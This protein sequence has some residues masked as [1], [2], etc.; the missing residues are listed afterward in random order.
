MSGFGVN[1]FASTLWNVA[2]GGTDFYYSDYASGA[3]SAATAAGSH[4]VVASYSGDASY[5]PS[6]SSPFTYTVKTTTVVL[7]LAPGGVCGTGTTCTAY[8]GDTVPVEVYLEGT[9]CQIPTGTVT[10]TLGSQTQTV[11]LSLEGSYAYQILTGIA[12]F[13]NLTPGTY[14]L[15]AT[16]SGDNNY[17]AGST[18]GLSVAVV[19]PS[20]QRSPTTI[21]ESAPTVQYPAGATTEFTVTVT[22][23]SSSNGAP[24]GT[25]YIYANGQGETAVTLSPSGPNSASG[26]SSPQLGDYF[27]LGL[28]Q[29]TAVYTGDSTYQESLSAPIILTA[30]EARTT[31]NFTL[32]AQTPQFTVPKG[33]SAGTSINLASV[34]GFTG[35]VSLSCTTS[36][37]DIGCSVSPT[38][39]NVNGT[40]Q[41]TL[42]VSSTS[43]AAALGAARPMPRGS[44]LWMFTGGGSMLGCF[45][46]AGFSKTKRNLRYL[47]TMIILALVVLWVAC[48][49]GQ[50]TPPAT[51]PPQQPPPPLSTYGVVVTG[52]AA[53]GT[54][55]NARLTVIVR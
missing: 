48:G 11:P 55:H 46:L 5:N 41:V 16:Y 23:G 44:K 38:S 27:N 8:A 6:Q 30:V 1:G 50:S 49:G 9:G 10:V 7:N 51:T 19:A 4:S 43:A 39:V 20:G 42:T 37:T 12:E 47:G 54:I 24:T 17:Q 2:V 40:A 34:Y 13:S 53:S 18:S 14:Q 35:I 26:T 28:N 15:S 25:V 52:T 32:A 3:P 36:A 29:I 33:S 31:P 22:G 45:F 21:S